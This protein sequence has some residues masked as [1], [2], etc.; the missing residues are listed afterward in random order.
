MGGRKEDVG[1]TH[2]MPVPDATMSSI[3]PSGVKNAFAIWEIDFVGAMLQTHNGNRSIITAI[4]Y[5]TSRAIARALKERSAM[6]AIEIL[7]EI[8]WSYGKPTEIVID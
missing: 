1:F 7:E 3:H 6:A 8:I 5:A 4:D 2:Y